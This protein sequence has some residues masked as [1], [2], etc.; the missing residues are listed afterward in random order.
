[1]RW[2]RAAGLQH[3]GYPL[4]DVAAVQ[5]EALDKVVWPRVDEVQP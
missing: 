4:V 1:M 2:L 5:R 3:L